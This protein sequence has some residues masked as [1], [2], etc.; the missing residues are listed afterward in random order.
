M[1]YPLQLDDD[2]ATNQLSPVAQKALAGRLLPMASSPMASPRSLAANSHKTRS[3]KGTQALP[4][5]TH[6]LNGGFSKDLTKDYLSLRRTSIEQLDLQR[7]TIQKRFIKL[8]RLLGNAY[9]YHLNRRPTFMLLLAGTQSDKYSKRAILEA[10]MEIV[11]EENWQDDK[12]ATCCRL[13]FSPFTLINRKHHC[14]LCGAV[15]DDRAPTSPEGTSSCSAQVPVAILLKMLP[16]LNYLP[17]IKSQW[18]AFCRADSTDQGS[19]LVFSFRCCKTCK[20]LLTHEVKAP[21]RSDR[22]ENALF[23]NFEEFLVLKLLIKD[24][25]MKYS[26]LS[27]S[28]SVDDPELFKI[29][30]RMVDCIK[31]LETKGAFF[32][33]EAAQLTKDGVESISATHLLLTMNMYKSLM[34]FLLEA[35]QNL[36]TVNEAGEKAASAKSSLE[37]SA[38]ATPEVELPPRLNKREIRERR[39]QLMVVNEQKFLVEDLIR[40]TRKQRKFDEVATL[41]ESK[42]DLEEKIKELEVELGEYGF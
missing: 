42:R 2:L 14:R 17:E 25:G 28:T 37:S 9:L 18:D 12:D 39:E 6:P 31:E 34:I 26:S 13:C 11:G 10:E 16:H 22:P 40:N 8:A 38:Q 15:V 7:I 29:R 1:P 32:K 19:S 4:V 36:K 33:N 41:E 20:N 35:I 24:L 21:T 23:T 27:K 30:A 3:K 5:S